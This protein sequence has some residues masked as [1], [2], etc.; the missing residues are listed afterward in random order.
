MVSSNISEQG[1]TSARVAE[2]PWQTNLSPDLLNV[3]TVK[4][5]TLSIFGLYEYVNYLRDNGLDAAVYE[6]A[7]WGK[8]VAPLVTAVMVFLAI[9]FVFG[10]LRSVGVGHR[11]LVGTLAGVGFYILNQMFAYMGLVFGFNPLL[12]ALAPALLAF[13]AGYYMLRRLY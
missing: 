8:V 10:P 11:I 5:N 3:V 2:A 1:V 12:S 4:P 9:P 7:L 6:Q 13:M